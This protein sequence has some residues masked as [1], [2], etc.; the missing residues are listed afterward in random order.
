MGAVVLG[1]KIAKDRNF[2]ENPR[3]LGNFTLNVREI[4]VVSNTALRV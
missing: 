3:K 1:E 2:I 4:Q